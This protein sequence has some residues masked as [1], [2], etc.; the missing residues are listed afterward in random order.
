MLRTYSSEKR[1]IKRYLN[2]SSQ[3]VL[4]LARHRGVA[5]FAT[6]VTPFQKRNDTVISK[7]ARLT[8]PARKTLEFGEET[9]AER[10]SRVNQS[11]PL[12]G[13]PP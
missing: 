2:L 1:L 11:C 4:L 13:V 8:R 7:G 5:S 12:L 10:N 3:K 6:S 9:R